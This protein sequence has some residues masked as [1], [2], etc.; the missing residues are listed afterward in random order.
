MVGCVLMGSTIP[1]ISIVSLLRIILAAALI[2]PLVD[3]HESEQADTSASPG[4]SLS[5]EMPSGAYDF[6]NSIGLN[7]H[8][9]YYDRTYGNFSLVQRELKSLGVRHLRDGVHLQDPGYNAALYGR[10]IALGRL[11]IRFDAVLDPR[12]N[13]GPINSSLLEQVDTLAGHTIEMFEGPNEMD[14]SNTLNWPEIDRDYQSAL[15]DAD[16][17]FDGAHSIRV[18]GPSLAF[19]SAS[20]MIGNISTQL[21]FGNLH[22]YP[23]GEM[24]SVIFPDQVN[25]ERIMCDDKQIVFTETGYHNAINEQHDQPGVSEDAAA[26]YIPRLFLEDYAHGI[27]R[28]YLYEFLDEAPE[29]GLTDP[30]LH[31][32]LIRAD[33]S[34]KPAFAALKNLIAELDDTSEPDH[35][36]Q[37]AWALNPYP[38][39]VHHLLLE[40]SDG[41]YDLVLWQEVSSYD[42]H[43]HS[44]ITNAAVDVTLNLA[45]S[46]QNITTYEPA[47]QE[48]P[49]RSW[50]EVKSVSLEIPDHPLVVEITF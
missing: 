46:A 19:A 36:S 50:S 34:E 6:V 3:C 26:K 4:A 10:W 7:T 17:P 9:N 32:G 25:L 42:T 33:G 49:V 48:N 11:G 29:P 16:K 2:L 20:S 5:A 22:P 30:Q 12:N 23:A 40:K 1:L 41:V 28:T 27:P 43:Q 13:L 31:W 35:L 37:L 15:F 24:P 47:L 21:D 45:R 8:L 18:I 14:V 44:D 38:I 39:K